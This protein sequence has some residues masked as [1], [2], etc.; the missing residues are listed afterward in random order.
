[1]CNLTSNGGLIVQHFFFF[2][3]FYFLLHCLFLL[4]FFHFILC[5]AWSWTLST[6]LFVQC[7]PEPSDAWRMNGCWMLSIFQPCASGCFRYLVLYPGFCWFLCHSHPGTATAVHCT[8]VQIL[9]HFVPTEV[10]WASLVPIIFPLALFSLCQCNGEDQSGVLSAWVDI[11]WIGFC[12]LAV[13]FSFV[14]NFTG[15]TTLFLKQHWGG[16]CF[17]WCCFG[18]VNTLQSR[19]R[20]MG[21]E[22]FCYWALMACIAASLQFTLCCIIVPPDKKRFSYHLHYTWHITVTTGDLKI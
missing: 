16:M 15:L 17:L 2:L 11:V 9:E 7:I 4:S 5:R 6:G 13:W 20:C 3:S 14:F 8:Q 21:K 18:L 19:Y 12:M 10:L 22:M 1:M